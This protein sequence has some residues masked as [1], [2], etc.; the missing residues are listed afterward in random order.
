M[1]RVLAFGTFD[2]LHQ[3]HKFFLT[4]SAKHG[5]LHVVVARDANVQRFKGRRPSQDESTRLA[6]VAGV[7]VVKKALLGSLTDIMAVI[8]SE[9]P[10]VICL[11]YDQDQRGLSAELRRMGFHPKIIRLG[12]FKPDEFK[13]SLLRKGSL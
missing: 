5:D 11:G 7:T 4:E 13:S 10:D 9:K 1:E 12:P 3:G 8:A 6:Q 2:H